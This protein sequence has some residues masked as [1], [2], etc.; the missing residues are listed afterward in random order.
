MSK[1]MKKKERTDLA[2]FA[3][4][5]LESGSIESGNMS[6]HTST[7]DVATE[8][9]LKSIFLSLDT[10]NDDFLTRAQLIEGIQLAGLCPR[11]LLVK[12]YS[13]FMSE[14]VKESNIFLS[15]NI[16]ILDERENS[17]ST[18]P[19]KKIIAGAGHLH[20][21]TDMAAFISVTSQELSRK[22]IGIEEELYHLFEYCKEPLTDQISVK[23]LRHVLHES[24]APT[25]LSTKETNDFLKASGIASK[26]APQADSSNYLVD[27]SLL[28]KALPI[29]SKSKK[30]A[31]LM[32]STL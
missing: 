19:Q 5:L 10:D 31:A 2:R 14:S 8:L 15:S 26:V 12:K 1:E 24:L 21:K 7:C 25:R 27:I 9:H 11:D 23:Q 22:R 3:W 32:K 4:K 20:F 18:N 28:T 17:S 16:G 13:K 6:H 30:I 29:G